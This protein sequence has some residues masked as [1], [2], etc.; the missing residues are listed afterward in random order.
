MYTGKG[1]RK[2]PDLSTYKNK[3]ID[4]WKKLGKKSLIL[5]CGDLH[6][7][8]RLDELATRLFSY[9][10]DT[11]DFHV[12]RDYVPSINRD[13]NAV[14][15]PKTS[16]LEEHT[17][18]FENEEEVVQ[19]YDNVSNCEGLI[20]TSAGTSHGGQVVGSNLDTMGPPPGFE[21]VQTMIDKALRFHQGERYASEPLWTPGNG[22]TPYN[23]DGININSTRQAS[24]LEDV[25]HPVMMKG[26]ADLPPLNEAIKKQIRKGEF[27]DFNKV[28]ALLTNSYM[29]EETRLSYTFSVENNFNDSNKKIE[30]CPKD[31]T[32]KRVVDLLSWLMAWTAYLEVFSNFHPHLTRDLFKYQ[33]C[34]VNLASQYQVAAWLQYDRSFRYKMAT[35]VGASWKEEDTRLFNL[36]LRGREKYLGSSIFKRNWM[37]CNFCKKGGHTEAFCFQANRGLRGTSRN[38]QNMSGGLTSRVE[39]EGRPNREIGQRTGGVCYSYNN[40]GKC[41]RLRCQFQHKCRK[42]SGTH[43]AMSCP[44]QY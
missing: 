23:E 16:F 6:L 12:N 22:N 25:E 15:G 29:E 7:E 24:P 10:Q 42:C 1:K 3:T 27:V 36:H 8:G 18:G 38:E 44:G 32:V 14:F 26:C 34:I 35:T 13:G 33:A 41:D 40:Q 20:D 19:D 17:I 30:I 2:A 28:Y 21:W 43:P 5:H 39:N 37:I 31:R 4:D 9:Y 11:Q